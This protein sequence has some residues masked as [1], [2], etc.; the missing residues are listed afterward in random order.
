MVELLVPNEPSQRL[1]E[2]VFDYLDFPNVRQSVVK[3]EGKGD[4]HDSLVISLGPFGLDKDTGITK[5]LVTASEL[6][7]YSSQA[8]MVV[9]D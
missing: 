5:D 2:F 6:T 9:S 8:L 3:M 4:V 1:Y 7:T